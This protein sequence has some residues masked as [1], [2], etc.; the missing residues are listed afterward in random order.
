MIQMVEITPK[1]GKTDMDIESIPNAVVDSKYIQSRKTSTKQTMKVELFY[2]IEKLL[3]ETVLQ[4]SWPVF[5]VYNV[6]KISELYCY[7][8]VLVKGMV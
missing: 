3:I 2:L 8:D 5:Q 4:G 1:H 7:M 6:T